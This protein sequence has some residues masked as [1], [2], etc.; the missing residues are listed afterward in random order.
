FGSQPA[1]TIDGAWDLS[2]EDG[3][4]ILMTSVGSSNL[5]TWNSL[6]T[7]ASSASP[8]TPEYLW[9][10]L[11]FGDVTA[12]GTV[13]LYVD[14]NETLHLAIQDS[15]LWDVE[16]LRLY[17][18]ADRDLI[19]D[20]VDDLPLLGNQWADSDGDGYGDNALGPLHD[21]CETTNAP[22]SYYTYG[23]LDYDNDGYADVDDACNDDP[24]ESWIDRK[25]CD[26]YDQDGWSNNKFNY[27]DGDVF[28][29]N[30]KLALDSDGDGYGDNSS[31]GATTPDKFPTI[32]AAAVDTD[33]DGY[34][35]NW[36]SLENG[37][38]Q[39]GL[40]IDNCPNIAGNS[41]TTIN[42]EGAVIGYY[43]CID[44]DGDGRD[45]FSD[46]FPQDPTQVADT[47]G[48]GWGDNPL[49]NDPDICPDDFG[50]IN[51]TDPDGVPGVGCPIPG[52]EPDDLDEDGVGD[53]LDD[54]NNTQAGQ[55]VNE[56]GCSEYQLDDDLDGVSN[57]D[58]KCANTPANSG[59]DSDGCSSSQ[60][61]VDS[62][63][64]G[65]Y[66]PEDLCPNSDSELT[67]DDNGCTL[68]QKD[69]D[70]DGVNDLSDICP[71]TPTGATVLADGCADES[72]QYAVDCD[73]DGFLGNYSYDT[74]NET[75]SGDAFPFE[76]TQWQ[77]LDGDGYGDNMIGEN[78][79]SCIGDAGN[80][81]M[82][83]QNGQT[84]LHYG[85]I[86]TDG[87][88]YSDD[89]DKFPLN[90]TQW[91]DEDFDDWGD[92]PNGTDADQCLGTKSDSISIQQA[93]DNFGC[94]LSQSDTDGDSVTDDL[95]ACPDTPAG[96]EVFQNGCKKESEAEPEEESDT[97]MGMEPMI[98]FAVLG[99]GGILLIGV[100]LLILRSR[101][102]DL[103]FD[104]DDDEDWFED[105][106]DNDDFMA[107]ILGGRGQSR[108]SQRGPASGPSRGPAGPGPSRGPPG[109][110]P[111][112][113][114]SRGPPGVVP[115][116]GPAGPSPSHGPPG[117]GPSRGPDPRGPARGPAR[118]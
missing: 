31:E 106:D 16:V 62:D 115:R 45:D 65:I 25:G 97:V 61:E 27:L 88:G 100:V 64:D 23:C 104:D 78:P 6:N 42:A 108:N 40:N 66:D 103:D 83:F 118:G 50:Y 18:D 54:C 101:N 93:K 91:A 53:D 109:V 92:N 12:T 56:V 89:G 41:T 35:N 38:N 43:G 116:R 20:L 48:D 19:F 15:V 71:N 110:V 80:S 72:C 11:S 14:S 39:A 7:H 95:D 4:Y 10:S 51:G 5:L 37:T 22:S 113:G 8:M 67:I 99:G 86:D 2:S 87:D 77:D 70:N 73:G 84:I 32:P 28:I 47:D 58:D 69:S 26:D 102:D 81:T 29:F 34:P 74:E 17:P 1:S 3:T 57:A 24:G 44:T 82:K 98:F 68:S 63:G 60:R 107:N 55:S 13:G 105:G 114:P 9:S 59:V 21:A 76:V 79:D 90:P 96:A 117:A 52:E 30:W 112:R 94:S 46:V 85:C 75:H 111:S 33:N 36:T 49:G